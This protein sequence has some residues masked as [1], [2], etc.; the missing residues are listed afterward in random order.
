MRIQA[1]ANSLIVIG[2]QIYERDQ[3]DV[4]LQGLPEE[5]NSFI[6]MIYGKGE[7]TVIYDIEALLYVQEAQL[8]KYSQELAAQPA[9][10]NL[11]QAS[12]NSCADKSGYYLALIKLFEAEIEQTVTKVVVGKTTLP[13]TYQHTN[14]VTTTVT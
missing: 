5:Y 3:I 7:N 4:I 12:S 14:C 1:I 11:A 9:I 6:M 10:T 2:D 13:V 8:Y